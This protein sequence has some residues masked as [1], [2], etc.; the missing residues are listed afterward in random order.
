M[1]FKIN[2]ARSRPA[3]FVINFCGAGQPVLP[4]GRVGWGEHPW[5]LSHLKTRLQSVQS[6]DH[7][8]KLARYLLFGFENRGTAMLSMIIDQP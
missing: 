8:E 7:L 1:E 4:R 2:F 6:D 5:M 3:G